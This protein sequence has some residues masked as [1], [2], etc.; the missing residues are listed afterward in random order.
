[1]DS[2]C[3]DNTCSRGQIKSDN[4]PKVKEKEQK[5]WLNIPLEGREEQCAL[6][7][8]EKNENKKCF[9]SEGSLDLIDLKH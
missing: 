5:S 4:F 1:M 7:A 9:N 6:R 2:G 8:G 3:R